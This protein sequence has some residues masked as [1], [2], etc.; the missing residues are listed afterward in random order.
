MRECG[1]ILLLGMSLFLLIKEKKTMNELIEKEK[2]ESMIYKIR[3]VE[4]MI[5]SDLAELYEC[6]NGT[7]DINKVY[8]SGMSLKVLGKSYSYM[9]REHEEIFV[10]D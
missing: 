6:T 3:G 10:Q 5:D 1:D 4:V 7:K 9:N 2:I 8:S